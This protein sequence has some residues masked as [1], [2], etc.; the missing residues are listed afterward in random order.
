MNFEG[1]PYYTW[2]G[3]LNHFFVQFPWISFCYHFMSDFLL[4]FRYVKILLHRQ[5]MTI[6]SRRK[7]N[8]VLVC[9][10]FYRFVV[11]SSST[12]KY[13]VTGQFVVLVKLVLYFTNVHPNTPCTNMQAAENKLCYHLQE[14]TDK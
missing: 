11:L 9:P 8:L 10:Y 4:F 2:I 3:I 1:F 14:N 13:L 7:P 6:L 12:I 5:Q